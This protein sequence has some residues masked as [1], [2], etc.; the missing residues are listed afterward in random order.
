MNTP[1]L[2]VTLLHAVIAMYDPIYT[3]WRKQLNFEDALN[4]NF[5]VKISS[6]VHHNVIT[7]F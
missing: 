3:C 1:G 2:A 7:K 5:V 4:L 6:D